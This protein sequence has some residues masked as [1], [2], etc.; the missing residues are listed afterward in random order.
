ME[1]SIAAERMMC[2]KRN[3]GSRLSNSSLCS[4]SSESEIKKRA[5]QNPPDACKISEAVR[6]ASRITRLLKDAQIRREI[7]SRD[8]KGSSWMNV[9]ATSPGF[10][11]SLPHDER[12]GVP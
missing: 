2:L 11:Q 9:W 1:S 3:R 12:H 6:G 7:N 5:P 8:V 10:P 4:W